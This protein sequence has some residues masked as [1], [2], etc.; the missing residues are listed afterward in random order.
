VLV[1]REGV[2]GRVHW[3]SI[4]QEV[5]ARLFILQLLIKRL[6]ARALFFSLSILIYLLDSPC[7]DIFSSSSLPYTTTIMLSLVMI[8]LHVASRLLSLYGRMMLHEV[9]SSMLGRRRISSFH[10]NKAR[11]HL[12]QFDRID[13]SMG[14]LCDDGSIK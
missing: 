4:W 13:S 1:V 12:E 7:F 11:R 2:F 6:T 5:S 10:S 8:F 3:I 9:P 14:W